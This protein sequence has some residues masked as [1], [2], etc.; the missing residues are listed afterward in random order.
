MRLAGILRGRS[1]QQLSF[2]YAIM[3]A[4]REEILRLPLGAESKEPEEMVHELK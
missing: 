3:S 2:V 1:I 4:F